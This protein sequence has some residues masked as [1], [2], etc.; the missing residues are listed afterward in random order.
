MNRLDGADQLSFGVNSL[1]HDPAA[2]LTTQVKDLREPPGIAVLAHDDDADPRML[3]GEARRDAH[4]LVG[5]RRRHPDIRDN[6]IRPRPLYRGQERRLVVCDR[7]EIDVR[8]P[9]ENM[10]QHVSDHDRV[11][12]EYDSDRHGRR[13]LTRVTD[14]HAPF[15]PYGTRGPA[16]PG[17]DPRVPSG[18]NIRAAS[19]LLHPRYRFR[20]PGAARRPRRPPLRCLDARVVSGGPDR[21]DTVR[22]HVGRVDPNAAACCS[23]RETTDCG[24]A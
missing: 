3:R 21:L 1:L 13:M 4:A 20:L 14:R 15:L 23:M 11:I 6:H 17:C 9:L 10:R 12:S 8:R 2:V 18:P 16:S 19:S 5:S 7:D 22:R 24:A